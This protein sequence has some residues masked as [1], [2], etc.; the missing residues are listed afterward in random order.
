VSR[1]LRVAAAAARD[2]IR[3]YDWYE[4]RRHALYYRLTD[5]DIVIRG[6]LHL[7]SDPGRWRRRA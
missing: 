7:H 4:Q 3:A 2:I 6:C 5:T 1:G